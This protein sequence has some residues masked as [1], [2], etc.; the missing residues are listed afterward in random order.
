MKNY[1]YLSVIALLVVG[2]LVQNQL[3]KEQTQILEQNFWIAYQFRHLKIGMSKKEVVEILGFPPEEGLKNLGLQ[4][5]YEIFKAED[6]TSQ[7]YRSNSD[8][9]GTLW[10]SLGMRGEAKSSMYMVLSLDFDKD[11]KLT[12]IYYGG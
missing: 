11:D 9:K 6:G 7:L 4:P 8:A 10:E 2:I 3:Y 5:K 12:G 1:F